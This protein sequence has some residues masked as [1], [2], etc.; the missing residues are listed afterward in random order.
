MLITEKSY[1]NE[2]KDCYLVKIVEKVMA[3]ERVSEIIKMKRSPIDEYIY[4]NSLN[5]LLL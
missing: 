3:L 5:W 2:Y 1:D 4:F